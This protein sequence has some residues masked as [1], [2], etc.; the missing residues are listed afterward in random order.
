MKESEGSHL[1]RTTKQLDQLAWLLDNCFRIPGLKWRFGL[2]ALIGLIPGAGDVA[3]GILSLLLLVRAFQFRLPRIVI[4]RMIVNNLMDL[5]IGAIPFVG[6]AFDF[7]WKSN[8]RNAQLFREYAQAPTAS[9]RRHWIFLA[10]LVFGFGVLFFAV[11]IGL[12]L[13]LYALLQVFIS[14]ERHWPSTF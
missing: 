13:L 14:P 10:L 1:E 7:F 5:I 6:D 12:M 3:G 8:A 4:T 2:E 9:T 11:I